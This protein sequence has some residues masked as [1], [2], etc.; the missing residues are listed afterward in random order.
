M[1]LRADIAARSDHMVSACG[2]DSASIFICDR[3]AAAPRLSYL[4]H[5]GISD[6]AQRTYKQ[7]RVFEGDPFTRVVQPAERDG[8]L[9]WWEDDR[10]TNAANRA[11]DYRHFINHYAVDVVGAYVQQ[12]LPRFY[13]VIGA[14]CK[15]GSNNKSNVSRGLVAHEVTS[16]SQM[17]V[18]QLLDD[19]LMR[20]DGARVLDLMFDDGAGRS[21][22]ATPDCGLS[23]REREVAEL[24]GTGKQNKQVAY[25]TGLSEFTIE[26]HLRRIYRKL[27]VHNRAG[28]VAK[29]VAGKAA[30]DGFPSL[31]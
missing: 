6:E 1:Q 20:L 19:L 24:V 3:T 9:I 10:L 31:G 2:L 23:R 30:T 11:M 28:M 15:P 26:N 14:H 5:H 25:I 29:L 12:V 22:P 27:G 13:L 8:Q 7:G 17:V 16:I 21:A 18:T 4:Y